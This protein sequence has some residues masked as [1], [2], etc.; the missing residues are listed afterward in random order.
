MSKQKR[1]LPEVCVGVFGQA[2]LDQVGYVTTPEELEAIATVFNEAAA[3]IR[4]GR[5]GEIRCMKGEDYLAHVDVD[6]GRAEEWSEE[7][8][9]PVIKDVIV[10]A[11]PKKPLPPPVRTNAVAGEQV[12]HGPT[13]R[14]RG[15]RKP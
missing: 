13:H 11:P 7:N 12:L 15:L 3:A 6:W 8:G 10:Q 4:D 1:D 2:C 5:Q 14:Q 9:L